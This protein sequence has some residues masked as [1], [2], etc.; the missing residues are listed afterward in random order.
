[1]PFP[2]LGRLGALTTQ[3]SV[4]P[5]QAIRAVSAD[6]PHTT[7]NCRQSRPFQR[8]RPRGIRLL[9]STVSSPRL[10]AQNAR[11]P[12]APSDTLNGA[13]GG[14]AGCSSRHD[15]AAAADA[16]PDARNATVRAK[17]DD[18]SRLVAGRR[19]RGVR[20]GVRRLLVAGDRHGADRGEQ[21]VE[22]H[23]GQGLVL[24]QGVRQLDDSG[25]VGL[26]HRRRVG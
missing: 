14:G 8:K 2:I 11:S 16:P 21:R 13:P 5:A 7:E 10:G 15:G 26:Q 6:P 1:M 18:R 12:G 25:P 23:P 4:G 3:N 9:P 22:R 20:A 24:E 19:I 17:T